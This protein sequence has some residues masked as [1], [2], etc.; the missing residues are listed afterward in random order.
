MAGGFR[1]DGEKID[2]DI[3]RWQGT[4]YDN[5]QNNPA[6]LVKSLHKEQPEDIALD[7]AESQKTQRSH[8]MPDVPVVELSHGSN[9][10]GQYLSP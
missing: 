3:S 10:K 2:T 9:V 8:R 4:G 5:E 1:R 7:A 6:Q